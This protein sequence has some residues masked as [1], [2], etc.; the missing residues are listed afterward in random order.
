LSGGA[1]PRSGK[2][3]GCGPDECGFALGEGGG[4]HGGM[5]GKPG[6]GGK[7]GKPSDGGKGGKPGDI[8]EGGKP[9]DG[10]KGGQPGD[11]VGWPYGAGG[12]PGGDVREEEEFARKY[13]HGRS[14]RDGR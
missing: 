14:G 9:G 7:G 8:G 10:G 1:L 3:R 2:P 5:G 6:D 4:A 13:Q 11:A 12:L